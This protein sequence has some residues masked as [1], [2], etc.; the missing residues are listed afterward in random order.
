[1]LYILSDLVYPIVKRTYRRK[2]VDDNLAKSFPEKTEEERDK[3]ANNFYHQ[4]C[5]Y[6]AEDIKLFSM[7]KKEMIEYI[8]EALEDADEYTV[9]QVY[10]FL[11]AVE[12]WK[13]GVM[14][15]N[16]NI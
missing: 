9:Q 3:I 4:L 7:S 13:G 12:Y 8:R 15:S 1:M 11:L 14:G 6:F 5:D 16:R 10:E 2:V